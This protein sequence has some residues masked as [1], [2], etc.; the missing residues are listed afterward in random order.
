[1]EYWYNKGNNLISFNYYPQHFK[2][3]SC[4]TNGA[5]KGSDNCYDFN[6]WF[7]GVHFSYT[8]FNYFEKKIK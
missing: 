3:L 4:K 7:L 6:L 2:I 1:M 8:N 5:V